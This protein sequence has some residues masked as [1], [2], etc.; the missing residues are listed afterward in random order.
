MHTLIEKPAASTPASINLV[1][2][3]GLA[4][5]PRQE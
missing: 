1:A 2:Y 4:T 5:R 3:R